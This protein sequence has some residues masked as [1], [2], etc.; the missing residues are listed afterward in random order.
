MTSPTTTLYASPVSTYCAKVRIVLR[1]KN[2]QFQEV[3]PPDGYG[4]VAYREIVPMGS[5]PGLVDD[6]VAMSESEAIV[7]YLDERYPDP[8]LL[9]R[10]PAQK[11]HAR[12][13]SRVHDCWVEPQLRGLFSHVAPVHRVEHAVEAC[14]AAFNKRLGQLADYATPAPYLAGDR[15][16]TADCAWPTTLLQAQ[17]LLPVFGHELVLPS[18]LDRWKDSLCAHP[19]VVPELA[20]CDAA[21]RK[22]INQK[23]ST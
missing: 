15:L 21:M 13:V 14:I 20:P 1:I 19:A 17:L 9:P 4:S 16:S 23:L 2:I 5:I 7:E 10:D 18:K 6:Q 8:P 22:W 3:T 12:A 11:A